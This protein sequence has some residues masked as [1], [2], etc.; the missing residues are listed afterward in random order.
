MQT[1]GTVT[2]RLEIDAPVTDSVRMAKEG[3]RRV[4]DAAFSQHLPSETDGYVG[5]VEQA[6]SIGANVEMQ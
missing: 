6:E 3:E 2:G 5:P 4:G 1:T